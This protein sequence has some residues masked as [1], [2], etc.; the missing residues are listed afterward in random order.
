MQ[1]FSSSIDLLTGT[2]IFGLGLLFCLFKS[3]S[4]QDLIAAVEE[5]DIRARRFYISSI[6]L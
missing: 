1:R 6:V 5:T 4:T 3:T 2:I